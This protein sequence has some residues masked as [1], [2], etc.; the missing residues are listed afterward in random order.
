[1]T[2][3][4][5]FQYQTIT[6]RKPEFESLC[7]NSHKRDSAT[8]RGRLSCYQTKSIPLVTTGSLFLPLSCNLFRVPSFISIL[9]E[10]YVTNPFVQKVKSS[11]YA[12]VCVL[13]GKQRTHFVYVYFMS[14]CH[15]LE[16]FFKYS[17]EMK[18][19]HLTNGI[20]F[21]RYQ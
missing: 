1:M 12:Y 4:D 15:Y 13:F 19:D 17:L 21:L 2:K 9:F 16:I 14:S 18:N 20:I 8:S 11:I 6:D 3:L 5:Y 7:E 10:N